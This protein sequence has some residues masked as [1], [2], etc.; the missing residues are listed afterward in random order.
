MQPIHIATH[1]LLS[2][3]IINSDLLTPAEVVS[4]LGAVQA[5]DYTMSK[6]GIGL[7]IPQTTNSQVEQAITEGQIVRTHI[8]RPTWHWVAAQDLRWIMA[9]TAPHVQQLVASM[10]RKLELDDLILRKASEVMT[11][12]LA[13]HNYLTR[14]ELMTQ[15]EQAGII[16]SDLR[17]AHLMAYAELNCLVCNGPMR[18]KQITYALVDE[19]I[20]ATQSLYREEA[21]GKLA[22]KYF[23]SHG[24]A[25]VQD[26]AWWSGLKITDA[27]KAVALVESSFINEKINDQLYY[28]L[29]SSSISTHS[30]HLLPA[31]DEFMVSYKDRTASLSPNKH[32]EAITGNGIFKPII[33][34]DGKVTGIW[35]KVISKK[36]TKVQTSFFDTDFES[37][38]LEKALK[39]Y[40]HFLEK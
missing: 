18:D 10:N 15:I 37:D 16:T 40:I 2:Q 6:W 31:F 32:Q 12:A 24:P 19:R 1:R 20:P 36:Q 25:T 8:M 7:R 21:L 13:G 27:R 9:L 14:S 35:K 26:F 30:V 39:Q 11:T 29:N 4:H 5:Q 22:L 17:A 28:F 3:K 23:T 38:L 33:V 34:V